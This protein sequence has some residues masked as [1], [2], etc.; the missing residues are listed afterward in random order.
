MKTLEEIKEILNNYNK[1]V[2]LVE[3]KVIIMEENDNENVG[4]LNVGNEI[5][6][7]IKEKI[8]KLKLNN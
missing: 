7:K 1:L 5:Q 8:N 4:R 6:F 3:K 2:E